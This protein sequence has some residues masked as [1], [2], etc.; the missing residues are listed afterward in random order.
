MIAIWIITL[1]LLTLTASKVSATLGP[2]TSG[3]INSATGH[4]RRAMLTI[5]LFFISGAGVLA[6]GPLPAQSLE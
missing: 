3:L 5:G 1:L 4:Q 6:R 2:L